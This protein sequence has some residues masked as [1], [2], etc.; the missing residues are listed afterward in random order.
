M[1][2]LLTRILSTLD[3]R[4]LVRAYVISVIYG[5]LIYFSISQAERSAEPLLVAMLP[6]CGLL[7]PFSKL[8]WDE[9]KA[10]VLGE[11]M[12]ILPIIFLY[13][14]KLFINA[15]LWVLSPCIAP[16]GLLWLW[17]NSRN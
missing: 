1:V 9:L 5:L 17:W 4:Y 3:R 6:I 2:Q 11:T 15:M 10:L 14:A 8:V 12:L 7:F 13:P 16:F